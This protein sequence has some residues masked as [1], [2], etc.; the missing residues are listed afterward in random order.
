MADLRFINC[1]NC[2]A[3]IHEKATFCPKCNPVNTESGAP[4]S[5]MK[6]G[7]AVLAAVGA[8]F[9]FLFGSHEP[10]SAAKVAVA[11]TDVDTGNPMDVASFMEG[12]RNEDERR[13]YFSKISGSYVD[14]STTPTRLDR[15]EVRM[16]SGVECVI[17][18]RFK[19]HSLN[20]ELGNE[21]RCTGTY[22]EYRQ[23]WGG[24]TV[25]IQYE[26]TTDAIKQFSSRPAVSR[27]TSLNA[28]KM[29]RSMSEMTELGRTEF[30]DASVEGETAFVTGQVLDVD[31][32][33]IV[34]P[35]Q[36]SF[37]GPNVLCSVAPRWEY[38]VS[39]LDRG[40]PFTCAGTL[41]SRYVHMMGVTLLSIDYDPT[42]GVR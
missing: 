31:A 3:R 39:D 2:G 32:A 14:F 38:L 8:G 13:N 5:T 24:V 9:V 42:V 30:W 34:M 28:D 18:E 27:Y 19:H 37:V 33:G 16:A 40:E 41:N 4:S 7:V 26:P 29:A 23:I 6:I 20:S 25:S 22:L 11:E 10:S 21:F 35:V 15:D 17:P 12:L 36:V 1:P